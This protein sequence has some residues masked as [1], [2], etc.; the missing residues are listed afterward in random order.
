MRIYGASVMLAPPKLNRMPKKPL[1]K[2]VTLLLSA[3]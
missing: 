1:G 3:L 2:P